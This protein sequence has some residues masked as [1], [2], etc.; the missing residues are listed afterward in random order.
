MRATQDLIVFDLE[1]TASEAADGF[2]ENNNII[3]IGAVYLKR[4]ENKDYE[5]ANRFNE[6][7]KPTG[8]LISPFIT[9]LTGIT[10]EAVENA[11]NF[12]VV[13][14]RFTKWAE[15]NGSLKNARLCAWGTYF[16]L[17]LLRAAYR[18]YGKKFPFSGT[19]YDVKTLA[20]LWM[21][22]AGKRT[23]KLTVKNVSQA[24]GIKPTGR[25][26]DASVDAELTALIALRIFT[27]LDQ[28]FFIEG[29]D[30]TNHFRLL[31]SRELEQSEGE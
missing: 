20:A 28:G 8:E 2:Q 11:P 30:G 1:T 5:I 10:N 14:E 9:E 13:G 25:L 31:R 17:P 26:H 18:R 15:A 7:I 19:A 23:D 29:K 21:M 24:M 4:V 16:D 12:E 27:D 22:L 3:Q 6:L